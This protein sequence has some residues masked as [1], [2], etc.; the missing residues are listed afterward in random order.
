MKKA[1]LS[2][3]TV[4]L[5]VLVSTNYCFAASLSE[6]TADAEKIIF[7]DDGGYITVEVKESTSDQIDPKSTTE[8]KSKSG[9]VTYTKKSASGTLLWVAVLNGIFTYD[10]SSS[11]C[12]A[13]NCNVTFYDSH[14]SLTGNQAITAGNTAIGTITIAY[15]ILGITVSTET[16]TLTLSCDSNGNLF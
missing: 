7:C 6:K 2:I 13:S 4:I 12:I 11:S 10:G 9:S 16:H 8:I 1:F 5:I 15:K 14:Y 3:I